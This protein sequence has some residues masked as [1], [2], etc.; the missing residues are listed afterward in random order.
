M[1]AIVVRELR[2]AVRSRYVTWMLLFF[3]GA[4]CIVAG[5]VLIGYSFDANANLSAMAETGR[6]LF[7]FLFSVLVMVTM[8]LVPL[9][10]GIRFASERADDSMDLFFA[11]SLSPHAVIRGKLISAGALVLLVFSVC[12]PFIA[13]SQYLR[14]ID[15]ETILVALCLTFVSVMMATMGA[16]FIA[17]LPAGR[18]VKTMV[19][20][21][22]LVML[23]RFLSPA[24]VMSSGLFTASRA[25]Q[26]VV[27]MPRYLQLLGVLASYAGIFVMLYVFAVSL[28]MPPMAN[29]A[30]VT[31]GTCGVLWLLWGGVVMLD[32]YLSGTVS[33]SR[34]DAWYVV[35][36]GCWTAWLCI[37]MLE[38]DRVSNR[39]RRFIPRV[40]VVRLVAPLLCSGPATGLCFAMLMAAL[41][42]V[43]NGI[44]AYDIWGT[45]N[46]LFLYTLGA[47]L[48][49]HL[50]WR[51]L[52]PTMHRMAIIA[53]ATLLLGILSLLPLLWAVC[54]S[55]DVSPCHWSVFSVYALMYGYV[56]QV[57]P[58]IHVVAG[59]LWAGI[60]LVLHLPWFRRELGKY[61]PLERR[62]AP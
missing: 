10:T 24:A 43:V 60:M 36:M 58:G 40:P 56:H 53:G 15:W 14:G 30:L 51:F 49:A 11:T 19:A 1:N 27:S 2:Q 42:S 7:F 33:S 4:E 47:L 8:L 45:L 37:A 21:A 61:K 32:R 26:G 22:G 13:M 5:G 17:C 31:R 23:M 18:S 35:S 3:L 44:P 16:L 38:D 48:T 50:L 25:A 6:N 62:T 34:G 28:L 41:T 52:M 20:I 29:R 46:A 55:I 54:T 9:Y 59:G 39:I 12:A 57:N